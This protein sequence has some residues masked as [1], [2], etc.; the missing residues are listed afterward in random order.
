M[1]RLELL[2][3]LAGLT[4]ARNSPRGLRGLIVFPPCRPNYHASEQNKLIMVAGKPLQ[5][6]AYPIFGDRRRARREIT[7]DNF[8][9]SFSLN[10][11]TYLP[12]RSVVW[13]LLR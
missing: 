10:V 4:N 7:Q 1:Q 13:G 3:V 8:F 11:C 2:G 6:S 9:R 12:Q 5:S